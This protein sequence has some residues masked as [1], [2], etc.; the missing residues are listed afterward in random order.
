MLAE[1]FVMQVE[2]AKHHVHL[3]HVVVVLGV[4]RVVEAGQF[5]PRRVDEAEIVETAS[6]VDVRQQFLKELQIAFPVEDH[7]GDLVTVLRW[8]HPAHQV[9][10]DDVLEQCR[11]TA[12]GHSQHDALH[13]PNLV[14]PQPG[15][16]VNVVP[17][18]DPAL[19]PRRCDRPFVTGGTHDERRMDLPFFAPGPARCVEQECA[20]GMVSALRM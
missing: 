5:R 10:G 11:L 1:E 16:S 6:A 18:D 3:R 7:H 20:L 8:S 4:E 14:G 2:G 9:L 19:V 12:A 15:I 17:K 13:H